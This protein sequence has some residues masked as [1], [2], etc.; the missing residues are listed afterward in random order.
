MISSMSK[1]GDC[2]DNAVSESFSK[3]LKNECVFY[4]NYTT[5]AEAK[6]DIVN[7]IEMFYNSNRLHSYLGYVAP[8][9]FEEN[10]NLK[11]VV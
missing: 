11:N 7:Y 1:K 4:K 2:W 9:Q 5:R 8:R 3:T 6:K 10:N